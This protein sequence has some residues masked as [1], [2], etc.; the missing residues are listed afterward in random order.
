MPSLP[1]LINENKKHMTRIFFC[2][3][4]MNRAEKHSFL[5]ATFELQPEQPLPPPKTPN[6]NEFELSSFKIIYNF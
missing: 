4:Y 3:F 2:E 6:K 5:V 1:H